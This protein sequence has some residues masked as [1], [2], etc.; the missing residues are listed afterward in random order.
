MIPIPPE[1]VNLIIK[2]TRQSEPDFFSLHFGK[3]CLASCSL[4]CHAWRSLAQPMLFE[5]VRLNDRRL[6]GRFLIFLGSSPHLARSIRFLDIWQ[7]YSDSS[8]DDDDDDDDDERVG[9]AAGPAQA[10]LHSAG[11][12]RPRPPAPDSF[13]PALIYNIALT[14]SEKAHIKLE[15]QLYYGWPHDVPLPTT[16][17]RL[18]RLTLLA[19]TYPTPK[20]PYTL[21]FEFLSL[22]DL[23]ELR[24]YDGQR[25]LPFDIKPLELSVD[26][27]RREPTSPR[28]IARYVDVAGL[29]DY[30]SLVLAG[31]M[32]RAHGPCI[33][34][35]RIAVTHIASAPLG[36]PV[37]VIYGEIFRLSSCIS[38][39]SLTVIWT[40]SRYTSAESLLDT[41]AYD[42]LAALLASTPRTLRKLILK[43]PLTDTPE[44]LARTIVWLVP[45][46]ERTIGQFRRLE[47]VTLVITHWSLT[48]E[49]CMDVLR[50]VVPASV[51]DSEKLKYEHQERSFYAYFVVHSK[52]V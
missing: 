40:T 11:V 31:L 45:V 30:N 20:H 43:L 4:V 3:R 39:E 5:V 25:D 33:R 17:V 23:D 41:S 22:F 18:H 51:A 47:T 10:L 14:M 37:D 34:H 27:P 8:D 2:S 49:K 26:E 42:A 32:V 48:W 38:L 46:L 16:P 35:L 1:I 21:P 44:A 28:P 15:G 12:N 29:N 36:G 24:L 19:P 9:I 13:C 50:K 52:V 7:F 6:L